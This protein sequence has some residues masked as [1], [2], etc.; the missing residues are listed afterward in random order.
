[1]KCNSGPH[2]KEAT[3][4]FQDQTKIQ[5]FKT[6]SLLFF[7]FCSSRHW[8]TGLVSSGVSLTSWRDGAPLALVAHPSSDV[9]T[10]KLPFGVDVLLLV[11]DAVLLTVWV[12]PGEIIQ[13][14][15]WIWILQA[16]QN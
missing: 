8:N 3:G 14:N 7:I 6:N 4:Q 1:M 12:K 15:F 5:F 16:Q 13:L 10:I 9:V 2:K 11:V